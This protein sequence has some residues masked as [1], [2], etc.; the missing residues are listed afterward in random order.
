[1]E[2]AECVV[3]MA[4]TELFS[5]LRQVAAWPEFTEGLS[6]VVPTGHHRYR[7]DVLYAGQRRE[8]DVV[9]AF[10]HRR[11]VIAWKSLRRPAFEGGLRL[12]PLDA[13]RTRVHGWMSVEPV[14]FV[15]SLVS[16]PHLTNAMVARSL[17]RLS[18]WV[19]TR[20]HPGLRRVGADD[21]PA[22]GIDLRGSAVRTEV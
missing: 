18:E 3:V 6:E 5:E 15:Q 2:R 9:L 8:V 22:P 1:M 4:A 21:V 17:Q 20:P 12:V 16:G 11:R 14:G 10:D 7:W 13:H 19:A